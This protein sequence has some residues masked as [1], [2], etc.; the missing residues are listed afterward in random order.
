MDQ[1]LSFLPHDAVER[2]YFPGLGLLLTLVIVP[3]WT[4][5]LVRVYAIRSLL[6]AKGAMNGLTREWALDLAKHSIR[7]NDQWRVCFR[8]QGE[9]A[10]DVEIVDYH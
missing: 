10:H 2:I 5:S 8:W 4:N 9:D 6:A 1:T 7:V 3:F